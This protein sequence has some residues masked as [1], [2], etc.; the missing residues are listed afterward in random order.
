MDEDPTRSEIFAVRLGK[1]LGQAVIDRRDSLA[2][3]V[4]VRELLVG[5]GSS[6]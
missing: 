2:G 1:H 4:V 5:P 3:G 6:G